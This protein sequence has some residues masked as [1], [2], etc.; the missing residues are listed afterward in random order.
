ML[1]SIPTIAKNSG[2]LMFVYIKHYEEAIFQ[3]QSQST[4]N[5]NTLSYFKY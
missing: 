1:I 5:R 2:S 4:L 3:E